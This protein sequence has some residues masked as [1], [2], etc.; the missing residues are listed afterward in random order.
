MGGRMA[1]ACRPIPTDAPLAG[2]SASRPVP[3]CFAQPL[4]EPAAY[5]NSARRASAPLRTP[6]I[7]A[8]IAEKLAP[9]FIALGYCLVT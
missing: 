7:E 2:Y 3:G 5:F 9:I 8:S 6:T 1:C 4:S